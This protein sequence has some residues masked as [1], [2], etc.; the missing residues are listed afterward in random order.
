MQFPIVS[1]K[2][3]KGTKNDTDINQGKSTLLA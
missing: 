1:V 3:Q 2:A